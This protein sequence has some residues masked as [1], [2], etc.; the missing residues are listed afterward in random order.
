MGC[1]PPGSREEA[2]WAPEMLRE[3]HISVGVWHGAWGQLPC[4]SR[5]QD[6]RLAWEQVTPEL[7]STSILIRGAPHAP[8]PPPTPSRCVGCGCTGELLSLFPTGFCARL[9][10]RGP[11]G[12][13]SQPAWLQA[14]QEPGFL[15]NSLTT[16]PRKAAPTLTMTWHIFRKWHSEEKQLHK[17]LPTGLGLRG[18]SDLLL[19]FIPTASS[20]G[21]S[22]SPL[23]VTRN[24]PTRSLW[25]RFDQQRF[26]CFPHHYVFFKNLMQKNFN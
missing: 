16:R 26:I 19:P 4:P 23:D 20:P 18:P 9:G 8:C 13:V 25:T 14:V 5:A 7:G 6:A 1:N 10:S 11:G 22:V 12:R 2:L 24:M 15:I 17:V 3:P 21:A